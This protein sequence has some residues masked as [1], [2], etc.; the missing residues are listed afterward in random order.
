MFLS[1]LFHGSLVDIDL[2]TDALDINLVVADVLVHLLDEILTAF[3]LRDKLL[4]ALSVKHFLRFGG[5]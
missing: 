1:V 3:D 2:T 4:G 5:S